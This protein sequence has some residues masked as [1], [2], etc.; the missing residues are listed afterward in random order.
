[1]LL[2]LVNDRFGP[3]ERVR[4]DVLYLA[5]GDPGKVRAVVDLAKRDPRDVMSQEY[6]RRNGE[7]YPHEWARIHPVNRDR[8]RTK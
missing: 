3:P 7:S 1:M 5:A 2:E 6:F 8:P 4:Y